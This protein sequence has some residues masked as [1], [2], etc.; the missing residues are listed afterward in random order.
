MGEKVYEKIGEVGFVRAD[1]LLSKAISDFAKIYES[2]K[3]SVIT[4]V[5]VIDFI[6]SNNT[7]KSMFI[8]FII[9]KVRNE[10]EDFEL[11]DFIDIDN[12]FTTLRKDIDYIIKEFYEWLKFKYGGII[13]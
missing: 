4:D 12:K 13:C 3:M 9:E 5:E 7:I 10:L 1:D 11:Y 6:E 2:Y 8:D